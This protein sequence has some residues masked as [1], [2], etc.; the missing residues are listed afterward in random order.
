MTKCI[1]SYFNEIELH[2]NQNMPTIDSGKS[3]DYDL[4]YS[5]MIDK[6]FCI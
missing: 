3:Y 4:V 2:A 1:V 5:V 6:I